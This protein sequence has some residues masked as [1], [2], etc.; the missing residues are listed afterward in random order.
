VKAGIE[1]TP[2]RTTNAEVSGERPEVSGGVHLFK[3]GIRDR[4]FLLRR[5]GS[6]PLSQ[7]GKMG[8]SEQS[9]GKFKGL[10]TGNQISFFSQLT[11]GSSPLTS[12]LEVFSRQTLLQKV[13]IHV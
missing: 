6:S 1:E 2:I 9:L 13:W 5:A 10:E 7:S 12:A 3:K 8:R 4:H 11:S